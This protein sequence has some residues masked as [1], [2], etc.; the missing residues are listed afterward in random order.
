MVLGL[1]LFGGALV[2]SMFDHP[3]ITAEERKQRF[4]ELLGYS[5]A[6]GDKRE[7]L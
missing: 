5:S 6:R 7:S 4:Y 1:I 2:V 3:K